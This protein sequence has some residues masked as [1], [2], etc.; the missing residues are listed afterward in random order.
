M[1]TQK[2]NATPRPWVFFETNDFIDKQYIV[3]N[4]NNTKNCPIARIWSI[5]NAEFIVRAVNEYDKLK[6]DRDALL[7][8]CYSLVRSYSFPKE[9]NN[10][11]KNALSIMAQ[12][13]KGGK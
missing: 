7:E 2:D 4:S 12:A 8:A 1:T 6:A 5:E 10:A 3:F 13:E 9:Q 11:I